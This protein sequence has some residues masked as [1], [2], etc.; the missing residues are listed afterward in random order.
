[1][2]SDDQSDLERSLIFNDDDDD[3]DDDD[4]VK[5]IQNEWFY[6]LILS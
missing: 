1:M 4:H 6:T 3:D 2:S 5:I